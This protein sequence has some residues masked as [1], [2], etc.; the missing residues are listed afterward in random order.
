MLGLQKIHEKQNKR[1]HIF[2]CYYYQKRM[3]NIKTLEYRKKGGDNLCV[4]T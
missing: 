2:F 3:K 4:A 1:G